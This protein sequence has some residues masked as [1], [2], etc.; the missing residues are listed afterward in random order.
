ML[1][2][3]TVIKKGD[4]TMKRL[5]VTAGLLAA[6]AVPA[7]G[8]TPAPSDQ[9]RTNAARECAAERGTE[10][11]TREAFA[12][13][14]GS[15]GTCV[16]RR[17]R[18]EHAERHAATRNAAEECAAERGTTPESQRG[19]REKFGADEGDRDAFG[20]CVSQNARENK[21]EADAADARERRARKNAARQC[22][23]E[24]GDSGESRTAF[25]EKYGT[26]ESGRNAFG[27]CVSHT[28]RAGNGAQG[29]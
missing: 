17:S 26:N 14:Y 2:E 13:R 9:D 12:A 7:A 20:R 6:L 5:F 8:A 15:F 25:R 4:P 1:D 22:D 28:A 24:R 19:F 27:R 23:E 18:D 21:A 3:A 11:A 16:S 29:A 10:P